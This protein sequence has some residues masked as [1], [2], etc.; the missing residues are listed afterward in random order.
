MKNIS[1]LALSIIVVLSLLVG[2][3]SK[4]NKNPEIP[5]DNTDVPNI[6]GCMAVPDVSGFILEVSESGKA[7]LV[8]ASPVVDGGLKGEIWISITEKTDF[9]EDAVE[10]KNL[11][12]QLSPVSRAFKVGNFVQIYLDGAVA[13]S[14]PMQGTAAAIF[15]NEIP[16]DNGGTDTSNNKTK[17]SDIY[18]I[19]MDSFIPLDDGLNGDMKYIAINTQTLTDASEADK[20]YILKYFEKYNVEVIDETFDTLK[21]KGMVK[22]GNYIEGILLSIDDINFISDNEVEIEGTKFRS[23]KG[24]IGVKSVIKNKNGEWELQKADMTW[25]S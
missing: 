13:E 10:D 14:D 20:K 11:S 1:K 23:G 6:A 21:E 25:I 15:T 7:I 5:G 16:D 12:I 18:T 3:S 9:Y 17:L 8:D 19:A 22:D 4:T 2:C 24:A